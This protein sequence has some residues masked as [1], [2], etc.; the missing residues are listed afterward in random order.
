MNDRSVNRKEFFRCEEYNKVRE[1]N[2]KR[3]I[4]SVDDSVTSLTFDESTHRKNNFS[5]SSTTSSRR[6]KQKNTNRTV[7]LATAGTASIVTVVA[8][9]IAAFVGLTFLSFTATDVSIACKVEI[10]EA[11][12]GDFSGVLFNAD[13][14]EVARCEVSGHGELK[15]LFD[16]LSPD[17]EYYFS[18][19]D[20][21]ETQYLYETVRTQKSTVPAIKAT[22]EEFFPFAARI[23]LDV[24]NPVSLDFEVTLDYG[25]ASGT[26]AQ[27]FAM[28][29]DGVITVRNEA[30]ESVRITVQGSDG[31]RYFD[32]S[33]DLPRM[34]C[35]VPEDG[36]TFTEDAVYATIYVDDASSSELFAVVTDTATGE[37]AARVA[38]KNG[39]NEVAFGD[40]PPSAY[41]VSIEDGLGYVYDCGAFSNTSVAR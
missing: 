9:I 29:E 19:F 33:Y 21:N 13:G 34:E 41:S 16:G 3:E 7:A 17:T 11:L 25:E 6:E 35:S 36:V 1:Y 14:E 27:T 31:V 23:T 26:E 22:D 32:A 38:V 10:P 15:F 37:E 18:V 40:L 12:D 4:A 39:V 5:S 20:V 2:A 8:V 28:P 24:Y 30:A